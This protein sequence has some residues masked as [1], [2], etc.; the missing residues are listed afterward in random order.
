VLDE[1]RADYHAAERIA[2]CLMAEADAE[3]RNF[4]GEMPDRFDADA[5]VLGTAGSGR[6]DEAARRERFKVGDRNAVVADDADFLARKAG[7]VLVY[8]IGE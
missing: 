5:G 1:L 3:H 4:A 8:V 6:H 2:D 7:E